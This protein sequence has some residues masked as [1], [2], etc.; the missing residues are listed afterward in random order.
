MQ[1]ADIV[2]LINLNLDPKLLSKPLSEISTTA[3][4]VVRH[5][6]GD[7]HP[8]SYL[9]VLIGLAGRSTGLNLLDPG[10]HDLDQVVD[11]LD[12]PLDVLS[13]A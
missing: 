12:P 3:N 1:A 7:N 5:F 2:I 11:G 9:S 10:H 6:S 13:L 8:G 4:H